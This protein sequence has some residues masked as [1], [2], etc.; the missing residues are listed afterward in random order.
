MK[1]DVLCDEVLS[2]VGLTG[3]D[4]GRPRSNC[5]N[6]PRSFS[7]LYPVIWKSCEWK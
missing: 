7:T 1:D 3:S 2:R 4:E 5:V 6:V